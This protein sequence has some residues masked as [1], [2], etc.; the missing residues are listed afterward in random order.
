[1][2]VL[3][4][5]GIRRQ[6]AP[7]RTPSI[8]QV[9]ETEC[10]VAALAIVL[11]H[12]G[13]W[14]PFPELRR[15]CEVSDRGVTALSLVQA[16]KHY[17]LAVRGMRL[18]V[19]VLRYLQ[20]PA[21]LSWEQWHFVVLEGIRDEMAWINDPARGHRRIP[22]DDLRRSYSGVALVAKPG[23]GFEQRGHPRQ[24]LKDAVSMFRPAAGTLALLAIASLAEAVLLPT[25]ISK[26]GDTISDRHPSRRDDWRPLAVT[27]GSLL[28]AG[29]IRRWS[30]A[31]TPVA[32]ST[33]NVT[34]ERS[35]VNDMEPV[36]HAAATAVQIITAGTRMSVSVPLLLRIL[37]QVHPVV[38]LVTM[39]A[40]AARLVTR[41]P[42]GRASPS[43][44]KERLPGIPPVARIA[45][46]LIA[47]VLSDE[48]SGSSVILAFSASWI[49]F[50]LVD[51]AVDAVGMLYL[52]PESIIE[53]ASGRESAHLVSDIA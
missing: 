33:T 27:F 50:R 21:I 3:K 10:G 29:A 30:S 14:V 34:G 20:S 8:R 42:T 47:G 41:R 46:A 15:H 40:L 43:S 44:P 31:K 35:A 25:A 37:A 16:A 48:R 38:A 39:P 1:M 6:D 51:S 24:P 22:L 53:I 28:A 5:E 36:A 32:I 19:D 12:Y 17:G 7:L 26:T 11:A 18:G 23:A 52:L 9:Q 45:P 49:A 2:N 13:A 4:S